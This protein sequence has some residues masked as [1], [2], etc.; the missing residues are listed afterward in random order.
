M[1]NYIS[2][3]KKTMSYGVTGTHGLILNYKY[4][5]LSQNQATQA[6]QQKR[7]GFGV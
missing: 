7:G 5:F 2:K 1:Q 3:S 4:L 6:E